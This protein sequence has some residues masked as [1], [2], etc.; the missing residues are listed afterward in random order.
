MIDDDSPFVAGVDGTTG[1]NVSCL[2]GADVGFFFQ[3]CKSINAVIGVQ[4]SNI[5]VKFQEFVFM[6]NDGMFH[7]ISKIN[8]TVSWGEMK[9]RGDLSLKFFTILIKSVRHKKFYLPKMIM[10]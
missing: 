7:F 9:R 2:R 8:S 6:L 10:A 4:I 5:G 1:L 3:F